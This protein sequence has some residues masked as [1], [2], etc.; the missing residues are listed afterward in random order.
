MLAGQLLEKVG[1]QPSQQQEGADRNTLPAIYSTTRPQESPL[2]IL[3][4]FS[5]PAGSSL[6]MNILLHM[7]LG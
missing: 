5:I 1:H 3:S 2:R 7:Y 6:N 4:A